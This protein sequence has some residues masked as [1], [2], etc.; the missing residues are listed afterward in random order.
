MRI[1]YHEGKRA[2]T[3][4]DRG[5]DF[6]DAAKVFAAREL[7][8]IDLRQDYGEERYQTIGYLGSVMVMVVWT[9]RGDA[10]HIISMRKC[11]DRER[12]RYGPY[13]D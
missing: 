2:L 11:N 4:A 8:Q 12:G 1:T 3:L 13:L 10:R 5:L 6:A 7:T 9:L